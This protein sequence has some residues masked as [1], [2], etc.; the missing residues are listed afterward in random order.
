[1]IQMLAS[2]FAM[3]TSLFKAGEKLGKSLENC[4]EVAE[5]Y[6]E[7]WVNS[8]KENKDELKAIASSKTKRQIKKEKNSLGLDFE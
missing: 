3:L 2:I 7:N 1:M 6:S 8:V 5:V 4:A